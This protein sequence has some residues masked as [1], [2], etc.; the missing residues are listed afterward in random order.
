MKQMNNCFY[1]LLV[2]LMKHICWFSTKKVT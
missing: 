2:V 1:H